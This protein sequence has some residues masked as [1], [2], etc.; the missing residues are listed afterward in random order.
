MLGPNPPGPENTNLFEMGLGGYDQVKATS[1]FR[2]KPNQIC[3]YVGSADT[4]ILN[5]YLHIAVEKKNF[6]SFKTLKLCY[7]VTEALGNKYN[8]QV[9]RTRELTRFRPET[10]LYLLLLKL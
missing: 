10:L 7:F 6:S 1:L 9:T 8:T 2:E 5:F 4:F 3:S